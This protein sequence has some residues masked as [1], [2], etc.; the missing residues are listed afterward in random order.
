MTDSVL[1]TVGGTEGSGPRVSD[2]RGAK[3]SGEGPVAVKGRRPGHD[4]SI[5]AKGRVL[6]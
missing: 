2:R 4:F 5:T 1:L 3:R 6:L